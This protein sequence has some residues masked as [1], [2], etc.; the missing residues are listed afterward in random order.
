MGIGCAKWIELCQAIYFLW[1]WMKYFWNTTMQ[2]INY[3]KDT[4]GNWLKGKQK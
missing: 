4:V 3:N 1:K 2:N